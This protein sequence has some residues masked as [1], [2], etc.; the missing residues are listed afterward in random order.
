MEPSIPE[1]VARLEAVKARLINPRTISKNIDQAGRDATVK[2]IVA[3]RTERHIKGT[4]IAEQEKALQDEST[5]IKRAIDRVRELIKGPEATH[6]TQIS[7]RLQALKNEQVSSPNPR[8]LLETYYERVGT[9]PLTVEEKKELLK[10]EV[11]E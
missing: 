10:P 5:A 4:E 8:D 2:A 1:D 6:V 9:T 11:L 3:A 7:E